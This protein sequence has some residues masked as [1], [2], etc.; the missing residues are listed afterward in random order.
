MVTRKRPPFLRRTRR[1][2]DAQV[3][4]REKSDTP[5]GWIYS[6]EQKL[7]Q[8]YQETEGLQLRAGTHY[9]GGVPACYIGE[10]LFTPEQQSFNV[11]WNFL[12]DSSIPPGFG[13]A[14]PVNY[15]V[16]SGQSYSIP[17]VV[18]GPGVFAARYLKVS[19]SQRFNFPKFNDDPVAKPW[20]PGNGQGGPIW[21]PLPP[22]DFY[23]AGFTGVSPVS[24]PNDNNS[25]A[26]QKYSLMANTTFPMLNGVINGAGGA[27][28]KIN[29]SRVLGNNFFWN[30]IDQDSQRRYSDDWIPSDVLLRQ[31][32]TSPVDGNLLRFNTPWLF[33]RAGV[34]DFQYFPIT[35][36]LQLDP[37]ATVFPMISTVPGPAPGNEV[38]ID[39]REQAGT[40]RDQS[41]LV[42]VELHGT[43]YYDKWDYIRR[44]A[45]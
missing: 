29:S 6:V 3:P 34:I 35:D 23:Q 11:N 41:V 42:K 17:L 4:L 37:T 27:N 16:R 20:L 21:F 8:L 36:V 19:I 22:I 26:T 45:S 15:V 40:K 2:D 12:A 10:K 31:G 44:E 30:I 14:Q 28:T 33:E 25:L 39:D 9:K 32:S 38:N 1:A 24:F 18:D 13:I 7:R 43:K 5:V